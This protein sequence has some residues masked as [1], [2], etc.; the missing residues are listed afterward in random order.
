MMSLLKL[1]PI[2]AMVAMLLGGL[3]ILIASPIATVY[4]ILLAV[5]IDRRKYDDVLSAALEN[6][7]GL[8]LIFFL[9]MVAYAMGEVF[10]ATG[11]GASIISFSMKMGITGKSVAVVALALTAVLSTATGTS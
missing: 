3:D 2:F 9:L 6:A 4:A 5:F 11:V 1:S 8:M 10:M 7:K